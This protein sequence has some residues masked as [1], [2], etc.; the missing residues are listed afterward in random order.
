MSTWGEG[1]AVT[2]RRWLEVAASAPLGLM[3]LW[4]ALVSRAARSARLRFGVIPLS[5]ADAA[6]DTVGQR[7]GFFGARGLSVDFVELNTGALVLQA[8]IAGQCDA[9]NVSPAG[10]LAAIARGAPLRVIGT[11]APG[12]PYLLYGSAAVTSVRDLQGKR[13]G[14][15]QP[16]SLAHVLVQVVLR[17]AGIDER[18]TQMVNI[19]NDAERFRALVAGRVDATVTHMEYEAELPRFP[20]LHVVLNFALEVPDYV[21]FAIVTREELIRDRRD[22]LR[23]FALGLS[24]GVRF[25]LTHKDETVALMSEYSGRPKQEMGTIY[26]WVVANKV[27]QPNFYLRPRSL[28]FMQELNASVGNQ[29]RVLPPD[30]VATWQF[31]ETVVRELGRF[32]G[33]EG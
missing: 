17:E 3:P 6:F 22:D 8:L 26:D 7:Q 27:L 21:R 13:I 16:G 10:A 18:D 29:E 14:I 30:Q 28:Q 4:N 31:H 5:R 9:I 12:M 19:G 15:S 32:A 25:A 23:A 20:G 11:H 24:E 1:C 2:R 33:Y